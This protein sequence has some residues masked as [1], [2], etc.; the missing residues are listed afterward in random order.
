MTKS[1]KKLK[2]KLSEHI[3]VLFTIPPNVA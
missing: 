1:S 2:N 3:D